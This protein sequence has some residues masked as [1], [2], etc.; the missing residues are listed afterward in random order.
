MTAE[1]TPRNRTR[2]YLDRQKTIIQAASRMLNQKGLKGMT[3]GDIGEQLKLVPT[4]VAYYF[5][6]K[7]DVA[8]ACFLRSIDT[9]ARLIRDAA[10]ETTVPTRLGRLIRAYFEF[11]ERVA[12]GEESENAQLDDVRA[13]G[14]A[15]VID[16]YV[17]MFR[18]TRALFTPPAGRE[19]PRS[20]M[21]ARVHLLL[22]Q[23]LWMEAWIDRYDPDDFGR[24]ADRITDIILNGI[25]AP[26]QAWSPIPLTLPAFPGNGQ[27]E[28]RETFLRAATHL[29]NE[30]G[31]HGASVDRISAR[32]D[33]TKG[34]FYHHIDAKDDLVVLCFGRTTDVIRNTQV[35]AQRLSLDGVGRLASALTSLVEHQLRGD[36]PL[37]R[38]ATVSL[39]AGIR[40]EVLMDYERNAVRFGSMISDGVADGSL[41]RVDVQIAAQVVTAAVNAMGELPYW[42]PDPPG[43][44]AGEWFLRPLFEGLAADLV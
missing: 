30:Q 23:F 19:I 20:A 2:K 21:N 4:G 40:Q 16:A 25:G 33:V 18:Q 11:R 10:S 44:L 26:N 32:L 1:T 43:D 39:P 22:Q 17:S 24:A 13:L 5:A 7:E 3:L 29:I 28:A 36:A 6:N 15:R 34:S 12:R 8:A 35:A 14:D 38:A 37:L 31:Y 41:R 42:L 27:D 9:F